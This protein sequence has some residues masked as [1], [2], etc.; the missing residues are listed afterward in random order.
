M[1]KKAVVGISGFELTI[2]E[3][4]LFQKY[5]PFG[6]ILFK[7]NCEN[8]SQLKALTSSIKQIIPTTMIFIDQ[9]GGRV[10]RLREPEFREF[11]AANTFKT[12]QEVYDNYF[13][14]GSYLKSLG[15]DV[16]CAPVADLY[17]DF[18]DKII[19]DRSFGSNVEQVIKFA[20]STA[21]G[22][23]DSRII[24]IV[25]HIPGHGRALVDSHLK[26]PIV[27]TDLK[28]LEETDFAV[29]KGLNNIAMAMTAHVIYTALDDQL[30]VSIST[31]AIDY[32]RNQ[33]G[34][35]RII[36]SDD[37]N[38]KALQGSLASITNQVFAAGCD[39]V[40]HCSG[41]IEEMREVLE[42]SL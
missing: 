26:L 25:K 42:H 14:M 33:I 6:I 36:I 29:F 20:S 5:Q 31:K 37:I 9:E 23:M 22:L 15:I 17:Y 41:K 19:G 3:T 16:N 34:F 18:A 4:E 7:R 39:L 8:E 10:A 12:A 38:M 30:P 21:Q 11:P 24:P 28:T 27:D 13:K 40:L 35:S 1:F 2:E 32:I